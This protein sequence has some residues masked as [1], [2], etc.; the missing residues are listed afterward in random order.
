MDKNSMC[1]LWKLED[2]SEI[3]S[4]QGPSQWDP[5]K[6]GHQIENWWECESKNT[7]FV[8]E[9]LISQEY[10]LSFWKYIFE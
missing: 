7:F 10:K 2:S 1:L 9:P 6:G 5:C 4:P 3:L 8:G